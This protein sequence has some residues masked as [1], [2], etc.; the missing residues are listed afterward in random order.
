M[1]EVLSY[2]TLKAER[3]ALLEDN[4]VMRDTLMYLVDPGNMPNYHEE[5]MG[6][7]LEDMGITDRYEAMRHGWECALEHV[8]SDIIP[9]MPE[10]PATDAALAVG[11]WVDD[12]AEL[13]EAK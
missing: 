6:C 1:S 5:A 11:Q 13:K 3:D 8:Y 2:E 9:D 12:A 10:T 7:G 4:A